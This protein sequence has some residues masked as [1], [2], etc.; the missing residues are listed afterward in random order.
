MKILIL[1]QDGLPIGAYSFAQNIAEWQIEQIANEIKEKRLQILKTSFATLHPTRNV[2]AIG[3]EDLP[4][5]TTAIVELFIDDI[6]GGICA[7]CSHSRIAHQHEDNGTKCTVENCD[8]QGYG[9]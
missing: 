7:Y 8:C 4:T 3:L 6:K 2:K 5:L 1:S 9:E